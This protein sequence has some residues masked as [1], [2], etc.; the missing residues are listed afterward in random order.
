MVNGTNSSADLSYPV[1]G[2]APTG[3]IDAP[4]V[5]AAQGGD[6]QAFEALVARHQKRML[7]IAYRFLD[8]YDEA[9]DTAQEAFVSAYKHLG[10]FRGEAKFTTWLTTITVN[11]SKN[12]LK[13]LK[14]RKGHEAYSLDDPIDTD[15]GSL[16]HD[17]PSNETSA[18]RKLE[19]DEI[20][21]RVQHCVKKLEPDFR[22]VLVLRDL[23]NF[24]YEEIGDILKV[25]AG[26]VKSRLFR[27]REM[28]KECLKRVMGELL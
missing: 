4:L 13:Q 20:R 22:E 14:S 15:D 25:R 1:A 2:N 11:F 26:T 27:A 9:C 7:N 16:K 21:Q 17:P 10:S 3:D 19:Q 28:V 18:L 5:A 8:D 24:S 12:R 23:Q 6:L